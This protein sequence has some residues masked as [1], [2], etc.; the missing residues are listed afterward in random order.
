M[1]NT[2]FYF[3][4]IIRVVF[5]T[6]SAIGLAFAFE[7]DLFIIVGIAILIIC[8]QVFL[9]IS[10]VNQINTR[11]SYFFNAIE[12]EDF[13][14]N[15]PNHNNVKS[16]ER[17][18]QSLNKINKLI[19]DTYLKKQEQELFYQEILKQ[20]NI[21]ILT[22]NKSGHILFS[23]STAE[24][25]LNYSP[26][27]HIKQLA[28]VDKNLYKFISNI[29]N[30]DQR[31]FELT[32]ERERIQLSVKSTILQTSE[33]QLYLVVI[34]DIYKE[35]EE[36]ETDSWTKL[37]RVL[38]HEIMNSIAPINSI[39]ESILKYY[40]NDSSIVSINDLNTKQI[41]NTVKGLEVISDQVKNL[42]SFVDSYRTLLSI[43]EPSREIVQIKPLLDNLLLLINKEEPT[44]SIEVSVVPENLDFFIDTKQIIQILLNL[45]KNAIQ[46]VGT[47]ENSSIKISAGIE[48]TIKKF[49]RV[50]DNG[51]GIPPKILD[52][53]FVPFFT[54]KN[55]GTGIGLS[56][57]K[58]ILRLHEG[59]IK[60]KSIPNKE[61]SFTLYF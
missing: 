47:A 20:V 34:Q 18:H 54:T 58:Q 50:T 32:N 11:I 12:N 17:L 2:N 14:L 9:L 46:S 36:K 30:S 27:N 40:K 23:N 21:G 38:T 49:I 13:S 35:L 42:T 52:Q 56:I 33:H 24:R 59:T 5:I 22:F 29:E 4:V 8:V 39:S 48:E 45:S 15:I 25:L 28:Q 1:I 41:Q 19:H 26:L 31:L 10:Y 55:N 6:L 44:I 51:P 7:R 16:F 43:P 57:S 61:T 3:Q 53:I 60:V 37:I